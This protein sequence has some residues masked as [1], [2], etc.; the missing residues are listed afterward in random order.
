MQGGEWSPWRDLRGAQRDG[1]ISTSA[2][3]HR[4]RRPDHPGLLYI[5]QSGRLRARLGDLQAV[6]K[7]DIPYNDPH[8]AAPCLWVLRVHDGAEL[9]V[10][11]REA[12]LE[13]AQRKALE[14]VE[15]SLHRREYLVSPYA[16]FGRMPPGW[17]KSSQNNVK[18]KA[19]GAL[20]RGHE[21][22]TAVRTP[23]FHS[24]LDT[25]RSPVVADW[26]GFDWTPW[27]WDA[28]PADGV[29]LYRIRQPGEESL[30]Y[31]GQGRLRS[32]LAR[33]RVAVVGD[34][35]TDL[36]PADAGHSWVV[37]PDLGQQQL[38]ECENDLI[39]SHVM[40][41][42]KTPNWQFRRY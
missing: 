38:L 39:A 42:G 24:V 4:V 32:R 37:L 1:G 10:S 41:I 28:P 20:R 7:D 35:P 25:E 17:V 9:E 19:K 31:V 5:G 3:L 36:L 2:G 40:R 23:D 21:D 8:T 34:L 16:N 26:A 13:V 30:L 6:F 15:V 11:V 27:T 18:L 22:P 12:P 14:C 33:T 29:G